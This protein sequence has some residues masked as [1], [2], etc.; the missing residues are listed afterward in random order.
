MKDCRLI[1]L[2]SVQI[3]DTNQRFS[4]FS[5]FPSY[6]DA[7]KGWPT[8]S[9]T[10]VHSG[11]PPSLAP[12]PIKVPSLPF[13]PKILPFLL[14]I[15]LNQVHNT[16]AETDVP[17][18]DVLLIGAGPCG[19]AVAARLSNPYPMHS[20]PNPSTHN[21]P[22]SKHRAPAAPQDQLE[23]AVAPIPLLI[24]SSLAPQS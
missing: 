20:S 14:L 6:I 5:L 18:H 19:L 15:L 4:Y 1:L 17:I 16:M 23:Q 12:V 10:W 3:C 8:M 9:G 22:S 21:S 11:G 7:L 24:G 2:K 13:I